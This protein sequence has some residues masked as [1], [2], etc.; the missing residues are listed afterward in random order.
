MPSMHLWWQLLQRTHPYR[1][2]I[3]HRASSVLKKYFGPVWRFWWREHSWALV[4]CQWKLEIWGWGCCDGWFRWDS[5]LIVLEVVDS[6][7]SHL[8]RKVDYPWNFQCCFPE[9][10]RLELQSIIFPHP[11]ALFENSVRHS[12][13]RLLW[14]CWMI[15]L[16]TWTQSPTV[17]SY[18]WISLK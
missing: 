3:E 10:S 2:T 9:A 7:E 17:L 12:S 15:W 16:P 13:K 14:F 5:I 18:S 11:L 1:S 4:L 8:L 6:T